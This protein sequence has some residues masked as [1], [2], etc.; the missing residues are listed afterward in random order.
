MPGETSNTPKPERRTPHSST[1]GAAKPNKK[2][3]ARLGNWSDKTVTDAFYV[4][5]DTG[6]VAK[7]ADTVGVPR[8]TVVKWSKQYG[9]ATARALVD[10]EVQARIA[11]NNAQKILDSRETAMD[12]QYIALCEL[13]TRL[14]DDGKR[15]EL[16]IRA[17]SLIIDTMART[18]NSST[19]LGEEIWNVVSQCPQPA[20][21]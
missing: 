6:E 11:A 16:T 12:V 19:P 15:H 21:R 7:A 1:D 14:Q 3:G 13:R 2:S 17:L 9:W 20:P 5:L 18:L 10:A 8:A 4:F